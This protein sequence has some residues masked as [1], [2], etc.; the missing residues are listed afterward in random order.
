MGVQVEKRVEPIV[1]VQMHDDL[2]DCIDRGMALDGRVDVASVEVYA[3]SIH[4]VMASCH[5][6]RVEDGEDIKDKQ[7]P[8][9]L[10]LGVVSHKFLEDASHDVGARHFSRVHSSPNNNSLF[11]FVE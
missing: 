8:E 4:S 2:S 10:G 1:I 6:I 3:V 11:G 7:I 9:E 5:S